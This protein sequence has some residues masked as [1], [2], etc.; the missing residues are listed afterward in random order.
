MLIQRCTC[1]VGAAVVLLLLL[2]GT[3]QA[4]V[5]DFEDLYAGVEETRAIPAGYAGF[6]W[7]SNTYAIT[8]DCLANSGYQRAIRGHEGLFTY[9]AEDI[10][11]SGRAFDLIS[12][13]IGLAWAK[14]GQVVVEGY[15][16]GQRVYATTV[17]TNWSGG[18]KFTFGY[19]RIDRVRIV[20]T[21]RGTP[22]WFVVVD[23]IEVEAQAPVIQADAG[24]DQTIEQTSHAGALVALSGAVGPDSRVAIARWEWFE[25]G[26]LIATGQSPT[27]LLGL[28]SHDIV[29]RITAG[30]G[31]TAEDGLRVNVVDTTPPAIRAV[32]A[33]PAVLWPANHAM[34]PVAI[35]VQADDLCDA[36]PISYIVAVASDQPL[37]GQGDGSTGP[38]CQI[39]GDLTL[40]L[41][42]ERAGASQSR[43]YTVIVEC[44]DASGNWS[45]A[46]VDVVVPHDRR[47]GK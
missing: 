19:E 3:C 1:A 44:T 37:D 45:T 7:G 12:A 42:A 16:S 30:D 40:S 20:A 13:T 18:A 10:S 14:S 41:R 29:L 36:A 22:A 25:S 24:P 47:S 26:Q 6:E 21:K 11:F 46:T 39:T 2:S 31:Q 28:G 5:L 34:A 43:V 17:T 9:Y 8:K 4:A 23:D 27:V 38:D 15:R 35:S 32:T 33:S